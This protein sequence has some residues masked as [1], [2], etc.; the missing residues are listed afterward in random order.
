LS[1]SARVSTQKLT[2]G[3]NYDRNSVRCIA[4]SRTVKTKECES[5]SGRDL[6]L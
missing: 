5:R 6:L 1:Q 2:D 3:Q 4:C